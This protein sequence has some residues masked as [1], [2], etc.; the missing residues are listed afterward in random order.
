MALTAFF[1]GSGQETPKDLTKTYTF[2]AEYEYRYVDDGTV[3]ITFQF[4]GN[5][6]LKISYGNGEEF[7]LLDSEDGF[8][9]DNFGGT[10]KLKEL[11]G[12]QREE[13]T[14]A[15]THKGTIHY[16]GYDC[17]VYH[18]VRGDDL[19]KFYFEKKASANFN[20]LMVR[21]LAVKGFNVDESSVPKGKLIAGMEVKDGKDTDII[22][23]AGVKEDQNITFTL[24]TSR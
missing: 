4:S 24:K 16:K 1:S 10:I 19:L 11:P 8:T 18:V 7:M 17:D 23:L 5:S 6:F 21:L 22:A 14:I 12:S 13:S 20:A 15:L 3:A 2:T 9:A